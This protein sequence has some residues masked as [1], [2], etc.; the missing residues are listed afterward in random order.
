MS[1]NGKIVTARKD[2]IYINQFNMSSL[3]EIY[4]KKETLETLLK[5]VNAKGEKGVSLTIS[6]G[7]ETNQYGQNLSGFVSQ[8]KEQREAKKDK[9]YVGNGK[10]FWTDGKITKAEARQ[11]EQGQT[12]Q[13]PTAEDEVLPF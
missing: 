10:V 7:D 13:Q 6:I 9:F 1:D 11:Q 4:I 12:Q 2:G 8:T 3:S 5:T